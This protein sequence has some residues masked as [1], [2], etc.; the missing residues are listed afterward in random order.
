MKAFIVKSLLA[1]ALMF[2]AVLYGMQLAGEGIERVRGEHHE[3]LSEV[4]S[5]GE[6]EDGDKAFSLFGKKDDSHDL[7]KKK[8]RLEELKTYNFFAEMGKALAGALRRATETLIQ[9]IA[10]FI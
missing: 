1:L 10:A 3:S 7:E 6:K 8:E 2:L 9:K 5:A 4:W